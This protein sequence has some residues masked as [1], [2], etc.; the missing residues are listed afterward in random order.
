MLNK[1]K[2]HKIYILYMIDKLFIKITC[3]LLNQQNFLVFHIQITLLS[4]NYLNLYFDFNFLI[5]LR[6]ICYLY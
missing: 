2:Y 6:K 1:L 5:Y 4:I 3:L